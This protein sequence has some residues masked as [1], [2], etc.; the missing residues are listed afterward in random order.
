MNTECRGKAF[1]LPYFIIRH[2]LFDI[3]W[4]RRHLGDE[5]Y[6]KVYQGKSDD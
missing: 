5:L 3:L 6:E 4:A 2:C 1:V